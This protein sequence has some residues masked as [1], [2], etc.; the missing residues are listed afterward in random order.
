LVLDNILIMMEFPKH[1]RLNIHCSFSDSNH[2]RIRWEFPKLLTAQGSSN[3]PLKCEY[4]PVRAEQLL[5]A[6]EPNDDFAHRYTKLTQN[7]DFNL[8]EFYINKLRG[9]Y[10]LYAG[11]ETTFQVNRISLINID[12][13][14]LSSQSNLTVE[15]QALVS[16]NIINAE[17]PN[18][19]HSRTAV[20]KNN[21]MW[22]LKPRVPGL[23]SSRSYVSRTN[24]GISSDMSL[25]STRTSFRG[26]T[27]EC[28]GLGRDSNKN[29]SIFSSTPINLHQ[30]VFLTY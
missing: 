22:K 23:S 25:A 1:S 3:L 21:Y 4:D 29:L 16:V 15:E 7:Q 6:E 9:K 26:Q 12:L 30:K 5:R 19:S 17:T 10:L 20:S 14:L 27:R 2:L 24:S 28:P 11:N 8:I 18:I 13:P